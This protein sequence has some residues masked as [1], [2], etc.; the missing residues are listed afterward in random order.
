MKLEEELIIVQY[1]Q[2]VLSEEELLRRF[3]QLDEIGQWQSVNALMYLLRKLE[4]TVDEE[5]TVAEPTNELE[6]SYTNIG[7][8]G[9][10]NTAIRRINVYSAKLKE[11]YR[12]LLDQFKRDLQRQYAIEKENPSSWW[13]WDLSKKE[14]VDSLLADY[15]A[16]VEEVY[17]NPSFRGEFACIAKL[18]HD[19]V[20]TKKA[21]AEAPKSAINH[22]YHFATYDEVIEQSLKSYSHIV[23]RPIW[24]LS[25]SVRKALIKQYRL[26][27]DQA[28]NVLWD[29]VEQHF[30]EKYEDD[31]PVPMR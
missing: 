29:V 21:L 25:N 12:S 18:W 11:S 20:T 16:L 10:K 17:S 4:P 7:N 14:L 27:S 23:N 28:G 13:Y 15:R 31:L 19:D 2:G 9:K 24:L 22:Q 30:R 6:A 8:S 5:A 3:A 1:G 26:D